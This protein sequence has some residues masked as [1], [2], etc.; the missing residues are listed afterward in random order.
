[1]LFV[2]LAILV[3]WF[4]P[5][6]NILIDNLALIAI[7]FLIY[8][9]VMMIGLQAADMVP[10]V[11]TGGATGLT[12]LLGY[13]IGSAGAGAFMGLMVDLYGWDG[14]FIALIG[15]CIL[16]IVFLLLTLGDK[17]QQ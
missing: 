9:P 10:R 4:N 3:Y 7:G 14:G 5:A 2:I 13:L 17:G 6:G 8:G 1:M 15:A 12:G 16:S 11:A